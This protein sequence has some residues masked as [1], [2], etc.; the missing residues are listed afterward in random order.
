MTDDDWHRVDAP[1]ADGR[2]EWEVFLRDTPD[3]ELTHAGSVS[4]PSVELA[5]EQATALFGHAAA[6]IWLCPADETS[7]FTRRKLGAEHGTDAT[8]DRESEH[9]DGHGD[10]HRDD[11]E[12]EHRDD[13]EGEH[14]DDREGE[15]RDD[16]TA[17]PTP[18]GDEA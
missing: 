4:A 12:G 6:T 8:D 17:E 2:R 10:E 5:R 14:R 11:R 3:D 18:V 15:H 13:R 7:R 1:R 9:R 16:P